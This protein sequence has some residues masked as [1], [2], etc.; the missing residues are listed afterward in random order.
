MIPPR[1]ILS[2][3]SID[4]TQ[5]NQKVLSEGPLTLERSKTV[6][7]EISSHVIDWLGRHDPKET[8]KPFFCW[9]NPG[10]DAY[11]HRALTQV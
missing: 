3:S 4:G 8:G 10:E 1:P 11:H 9:Y 7:E 5:A 2:C 6:D